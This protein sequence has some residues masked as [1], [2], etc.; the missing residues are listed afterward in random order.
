MIRIRKIMSAHLSS[1]K[2][3]TLVEMA[4]VLIII[5]IIIGAIVKGKDVIKSGE[6][7]KLYS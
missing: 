5:G 3:F 7:K 1:Q 2:G 6:Q 4:I